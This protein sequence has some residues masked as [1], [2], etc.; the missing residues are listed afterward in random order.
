MHSAPCLPFSLIKP[1]QWVKEMSLRCLI[2][3]PT[4]TLFIFTPPCC[5]SRNNFLSSFVL[6]L[7]CAVFLKSA[8]VI[9]AASRKRHKPGMKLDTKSQDPQAPQGLQASH[10]LFVDFIISIS[11]DPHILF[12]IKP[13]S[14]RNPYS[15][16]TLSKSILLFLCTNLLVFQHYCFLSLCKGTLFGDVLWI[17]GIRRA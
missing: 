16:Q 12:P 14:I 11:S 5:V 13:L 7:F 15:R 8:P 3:I 4:R 2:L 10:L 1:H 17:K 9:A 6:L